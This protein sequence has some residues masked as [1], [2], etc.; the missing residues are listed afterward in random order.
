MV[1]KIL[2]KFFD[3]LLRYE[4]PEIEEADHKCPVLIDET[5]VYYDW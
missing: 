4:L 2:A 1:K 3:W 5:G